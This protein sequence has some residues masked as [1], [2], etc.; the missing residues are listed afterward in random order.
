VVSKVA[1]IK[2]VA[3]LAGTSTTTVSHVLNGTRYVSE[4]VTQKVLKAVETLNYNKNVLASNLRRSKSNSIGLIIPD[5][6]SSFFPHLI[7]SIEKKLDKDGYNFFICHTER[8]Q[9]KE[10]SYLKQLLSYRVDGLIIAHSGSKSNLEW[11]NKQEVPVVY[12]DREPPNTILG[13][14]ITTNNAAASKEATDHLFTSYQQVAVISP[15]VNLDTFQKRVEGYLASCNEQKVDPILKIKEGWGE[16]VGFK[17]AEEIMKQNNEPIGIFCT[18]NSVARGCF[19][20]LQE[21]GFSL[22]DRVGIVS[23]DDADWTTITSPKISVVR[24]DPKLMGERAADR[25]L[26]LISS[27]KIEYSHEVLKSHLLL[28]ESSQFSKNG[29]QSS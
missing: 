23:F 28:R 20:F 4:E 15:N 10:L 22:P 13:S 25:I 19:R 14:V 26:E 2:D 16:E 5:L 8:K 21:N 6:Y 17:A 29:G 12:V 24:S 7:S 27:K 11:L 1:S 18:T 9:E 3:N